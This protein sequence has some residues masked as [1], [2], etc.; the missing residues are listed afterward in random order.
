[1]SNRPRRVVVPRGRTGPHI[2]DA[3]S[4][5]HLETVLANNLPPVDLAVSSAILILGPT[6]MPNDVMARRALRFAYFDFFSAWF[7]RVPN[8]LVLPEERD[9]IKVVCFTS[10]LF[11]Q[12]SNI[13]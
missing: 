9:E 5:H 10:L 8:G 12:T 2:E 6:G 7:G 13:S 11:Q 1:M 3:Q 4:T